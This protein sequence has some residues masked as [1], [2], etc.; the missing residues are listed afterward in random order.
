[1]LIYLIGFMGAGKSSIGNA[2]AKNLS[3]EFIDLDKAIEENE[4][5]S[6]LDI[7]HKRG[8]NEFRRLEYKYL[9]HLSLT[10]NTVISTGGGTACYFNN[11]HYMK[12]SGLTIFL[13]VDIPTLADRLLKEKAK[14][15]L[16]ARFKKEQLLEYLEVKLKERI[17]HYKKCHSFI[18]ASLPINKVVKKIKEAVNSFPQQDDLGH[19]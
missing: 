17:F 1:M 15:P 10:D 6:I 9:R 3:Y 11:M 19:L 13:D 16:V 12:Q 4:M 18:D 7:F 5:M 8:E 14:R 2:L